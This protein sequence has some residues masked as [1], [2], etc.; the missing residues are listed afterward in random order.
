MD[1]GI[2]VYLLA[3]VLWSVY[4]LRRQFNRGSN[5]FWLSTIC[6]LSNFLGWPIGI[7]VA[8]IRFKKNQLEECCEKPI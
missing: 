4:A 1:F 5:T 3:S 7:L 2:Y 6:A 8:I